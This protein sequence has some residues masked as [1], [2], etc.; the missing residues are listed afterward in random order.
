MVRNSN[1]GNFQSM[2]QIANSPGLVA[3]STSVRTFRHREGGKLVT[4]SLGG[5]SKGVTLESGGSS[6]MP[7]TTFVFSAA[8]LNARDAAETVAHELRHANLFLRGKVWGHELGLFETSPGVFNVYDPNG[9]VNK[10]TLDAEIEAGSNYD[11]F[12]AP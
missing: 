12:V 10:A 6:P 3:L 5:G 7:G 11:P 9:A 2:R 4:S 8:E 1:S